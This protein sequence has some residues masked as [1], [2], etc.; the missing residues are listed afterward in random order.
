MSNNN[1]RTR[2]NDDEED[3]D[4][5]CG[6]KRDAT[7]RTKNLPPGNS[8]SAREWRRRVKMKTVVKKLW[9]FPFQYC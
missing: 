6:V 3:D 2:L 1:F 8:Y 4:D 9:P 5:D 7:P